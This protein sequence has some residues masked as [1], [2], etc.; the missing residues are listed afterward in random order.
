MRQ[1]VIRTLEA[2]AVGDAM[3]MPAEFMTRDAI[4]STAGALV[5]GLLPESASQNHPN[6][7]SGSVTDDTEQVMYLLGEYIRSGSVDAYATA[8]S[9]LKWA[10]ETGAAEKK[11][12]GPSSLRA[13][14]TIKDGGDIFTAG[15]DG[16]TCGGIMRVAA[17]VLFKPGQSEEELVENIV[18]CLVP[19]HYTSQAL[20]AA[21]AYGFALRSALH[22]A[23]MA[24]ILESA[25]RGAS[26]AMKRAPYEACAAS[27][28]A[29]IVATGPL[30]ELKAEQVLDTLYYV[31]GTGLA[32][33]D[34]CGAVFALFQYAGKDVWLA[35]RMG[36]S[37]GGDTDTIA[38]LAGALCAAYAGGH[39][40]PAGTL[41]SVLTVNNLDFQ[42]ALDGGRWEK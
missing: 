6:L 24:D 31:W 25:Q 35:I 21:G 32:S 11:Y 4:V 18:N 34:V 15:L 20:E 30:M 26:L 37:V 8:E 29:R 38:A 33:A 36:A 41:K 22:G 39:N 7:P 23:G 3:G 42:N 14:R 9:L 19:T 16:V 2:Y 1:F 13:L 17:A 10:E 28:A 5:E 27:G 40:I 12:I